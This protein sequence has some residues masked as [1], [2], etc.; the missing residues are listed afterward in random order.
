MPHL[1][2]ARTAAALAL[3]SV[4]R[5]DTPVSLD[6]ADRT[7]RLHAPV[8]LRPLVRF[9]GWSALLWL[10]LE[11]IA[12]QLGWVPPTPSGLVLL[13][14]S[15]LLVWLALTALA[16]R[17]LRAPAF[18]VD[19][20]AGIV[21]IGRDPLQ[22]HGIVAIHPGPHGLFFTGHQGNAFLPLP[23][24]TDVQR[25]SLARQLTDVFV[26]LGGCQP[27][28]AR[29]PERVTGVLEPTLVQASLSP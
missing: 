25:V 1:P 3:A 20:R 12:V 11:A 4:L 22:V 14:A 16:W 17:L 7:W 6:T 18:V 27:E 19:G 13:L 23:T 9:G 29:V 10:A 28:S 8:P 15:P 21:R 24:A 2:T 5:L 26:L